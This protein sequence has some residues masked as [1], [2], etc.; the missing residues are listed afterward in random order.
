MILSLLRKDPVRDPAEA[1]FAA[2]AQAARDPVFFAEWGV[3]DTPEG[4]F[5][6]QS[7][8]VFLVLDRLAAEG[9][10]CRKLGRVVSETM[11]T[12][13]DAALRELGVGDLSVGKRIRKLAEGF[14][15]R[16]GAYRAGLKDADDA[17]LADAIS[18]N[19]Y[20][21]EGA[22]HAPA[23]ASYMRDA[24]RALEGQPVSRLENGII[25]FPKPLAQP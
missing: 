20:D 6:V 2:A 18:R 13:L 1:L 23:F 3:P 17:R 12:E 14:Y 11:F 4:R 22:P 19:V 15:G 9:D 21:T 5:E 25:A 24:A 7:A 10:R 16:A 8:I